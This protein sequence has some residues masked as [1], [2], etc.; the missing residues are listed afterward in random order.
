MTAFELAEQLIN[1]P[2]FEVRISC[3]EY[4]Q[5]VKNVEVYHGFILIQGEDE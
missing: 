4:I 5:Q 3:E 1:G 2:N